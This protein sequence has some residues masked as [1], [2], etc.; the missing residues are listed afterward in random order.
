[1]RGMTMETIKMADLKKKYHK[2][3]Q[4]IGHF[5]LKLSELQFQK[6]INYITIAHLYFDFC[7]WNQHL[8]NEFKKYFRETIQQI[9]IMLNAY[10]WASEEGMEAD[11]FNQAMRMAWEWV[12]E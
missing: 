8:S 7:E 1:M 2:E 4:E 6:Q 9:T 10:L 12:N 3:L 11:D 5:Y